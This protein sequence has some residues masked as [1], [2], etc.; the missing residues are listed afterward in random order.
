MYECMNVCMYICVYTCLYAF[1]SFSLSV[2]V[3]MYVCMYVRMRVYVGMEQVLTMR[4]TQAY[5][6][7]WLGLKT[8]DANGQIHMLELRSFAIV[9]LV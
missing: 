6:E 1:I 4:E 8:M 7:N 2:Y 3:C 5:Q 9:V